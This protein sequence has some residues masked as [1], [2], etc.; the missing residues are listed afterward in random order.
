MLKYVIFDVT[1]HV[2]ALFF[3][4]PFSLPHNISL[5]KILPSDKLYGNEF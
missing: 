3:I 1:Y 5:C 4:T 2:F